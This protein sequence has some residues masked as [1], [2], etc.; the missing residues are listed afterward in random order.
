MKVSNFYKVINPKK[1]S[2][3]LEAL[4]TLNGLIG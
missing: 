4:Q 1:Q 3:S 2:A